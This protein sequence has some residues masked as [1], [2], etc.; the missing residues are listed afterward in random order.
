MSIS[1]ASYSIDPEYD[2]HKSPYRSIRIEIPK[3]ANF[4]RPYSSKSTLP[5]FKS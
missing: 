5:S 1:G 3:S 4:V 2:S